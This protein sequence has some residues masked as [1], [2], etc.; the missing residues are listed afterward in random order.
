MSVL[1]APAALGGELRAA[2]VAAAIGRGLE[3]AGLGPPDL[4][5]VA[6]GGRGTIEVLLPALGGETAGAR[7][8]DARGREVA[9]AFALVDGGATAIVEAAQ[10]AVGDVVAASRSSATPRGGARPGV[11]DA[12]PPSAPA[13]GAPPG[14]CGRLAASTFGVGQLVVAAI[15]A[16]AEVVVVAC[17]GAAG[18]AGGAVEAIERGGGLRGATLVALREGRTSGAGLAAGLAAR[19]GAA[20]GLAAGAAARLGAA[21]GLAAGPAARLGTPVGLAAGLATALGARLVPGAQFVLEEL[22]FDARMRAAR[23]VVTGEARLDAT[24]LDGRVAGAIAIRARQA[25]VPCHAVVAVD[26]LTRFDA[27]I[28]DLQAIVEAHTIAQLEAAG[29][30]LAQV[31]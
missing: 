3:R 1:V 13:E 24:T 4:C 26:A 17:G 23:A 18:G 6:G 16:G 7:V 21:G 29:E 19:L 31:L 10:L 5:P 28:L 15:D 2:V 11:N 9:A 12:L 25:G 30:R 14:A 8:L 22:G 27:R 20:G